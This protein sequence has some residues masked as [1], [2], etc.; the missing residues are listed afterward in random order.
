MIEE[1]KSE[2][3]C[4]GRI[5]PRKYESWQAAI[6]V[7]TSVGKLTSCNKLN[8]SEFFERSSLEFQTNET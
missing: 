2:V 8:F 3:R 1:D 4:F 5:L 7:E 6:C